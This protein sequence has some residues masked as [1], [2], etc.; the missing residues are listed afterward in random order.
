MKTAM[1]HVHKDIKLNNVLLGRNYTCKVGD[2]SLAAKVEAFGEFYLSNS[3][4][5]NYMGPEF[6]NKALNK[7]I[8]EKNAYKIDYFALGISVYKMITGNWV[9]PK[10]LVA[11]VSNE[12]KY[13]ALKE[14]LVVKLGEFTTGN[15]P[16]INDQVADFLK[17]K[18]LEF[19]M[20][21]SYP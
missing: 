1:N 21:V 15:D 7:H 13:K 12:Q 8:D 6:Y 20:F 19:N 3:G 17:R 10:D 14:E 18:L 5:I 11:K 9:F 16:E 2:F 4:T